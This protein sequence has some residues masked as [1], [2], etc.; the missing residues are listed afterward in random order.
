MSRSLE[1]LQDHIF[2]LEH[3]NL[4][5]QDEKGFVELLGTFKG[6]LILYAATFP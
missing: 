2:C 1:Y 4:I 6:F 3:V 5:N